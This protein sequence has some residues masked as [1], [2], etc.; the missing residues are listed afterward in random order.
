MTLYWGRWGGSYSYAVPSFRQQTTGELNTPRTP[1]PTSTE[2]HADWPPERV[3]TFLPI[4]KYTS[5]R[6][7][8]S[9]ALVTQTVGKKKGKV[10]LCTG[11]EALYR[12]YDLY[13]E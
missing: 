9:D 7:L 12:T 10:N 2:Q 1:Q 5:C 13:G 6:E 3:W 11:T 8:S 4:Q